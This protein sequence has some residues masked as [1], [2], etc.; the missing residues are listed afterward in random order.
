[1]RNQIR[2][3]RETDLDK[4]KEVGK[5]LLNIRRVRDSGMTNSLYPL[6]LLVW[7]FLSKWLDAHEGILQY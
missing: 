2:S 6:V 5:L 1:M 7:G 3:V 4:L